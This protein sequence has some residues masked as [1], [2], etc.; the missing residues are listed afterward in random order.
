M[1]I[2]ILYLWVLFTLA[3]FSTFVIAHYLPAPPKVRE[4]SNI[5]IWLLTFLETARQIL[6]LLEVRFC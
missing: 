3:F 5:A 6:A 1:I 4:T 2:T